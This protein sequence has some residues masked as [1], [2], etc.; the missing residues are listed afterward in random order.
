MKASGMMRLILKGSIER[1]YPRKLV[2]IS[3]NY[4]VIIDGDNFEWRV[5]KVL[6]ISI[7][8]L[9]LLVDKQIKK[10][11][12]IEI[13]FQDGT[14]LDGIVTWLRRVKDDTNYKV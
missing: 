13:S 2:E 6:D 9:K 12:D 5:C 8:G 3:A 11:V 14:E 1:K 4:K 10:G 7:G